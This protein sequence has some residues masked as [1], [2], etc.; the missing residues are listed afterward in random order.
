MTIKLSLPVVVSGVLLAAAANAAAP[1][2]CKSSGKVKAVCL[3]D[4]AEDIVSMPN[5]DWVVI[6]GKVRAVNTKTHETVDLYPS[7]EKFDKAL[8]GTCPGPLGGKEAQQKSFSSG[9]INIRPGANGVHTLYTL[10]TNRAEHRSD[11]QI[12][13]IEAASSKPTLTWIGCLAAPEGVG[14][15]SIAYLPDNGIVASNFLPRSFGGYRGDQGKVA[16]E[17]LTAGENI[18]DLWEWNP[19]TG[20]YQVPGSEGSGLN[21]VE[22]SKD[23]KWIYANE[24]A[25]GKVTRFANASPGQPGSREVIATVDFHP[26]NVRWQADGTLLVAGQTGSVEEVLQTCLTVNECSRMGANV[27]LIDPNTRKTRKLVEHYSPGPGF[28]ISTSGTIVGK[29]LWVGGIGA[30]TNRLLVFPLD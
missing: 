20:W 8:Y 23:G 3:S 29:E 5:S 27:I 21:G 25:N 7:R 13:E 28:D 9:G 22:A 11:V 6:S 16:R 17:K 12:F 4:A 15:N 1:T 30:H 19:G 2:D 18:S 10:H 24:W 14:L 26:D